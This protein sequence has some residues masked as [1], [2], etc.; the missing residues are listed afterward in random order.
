MALMVIRPLLSF[1]N[2]GINEVYNKTTGAAF[3]RAAPA[4]SVGFKGL[5]RKTVTFLLV[6]IAHVLDVHVPGQPGVL[7][8]AVTS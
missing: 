2:E 1:K 7:R 8:T 3:L 5:C 6:G 4:S